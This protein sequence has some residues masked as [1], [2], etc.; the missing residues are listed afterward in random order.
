MVNPQGDPSEGEGA[1]GRETHTGS[2]VEEARRREEGSLV[3]SHRRAARPAVVPTGETELGSLVQVG[4]LVE[5][6]G[7]SMG[8]LVSWGALEAPS[9]GMLSGLCS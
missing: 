4:G 2:G 1:R 8:G 7:G 6:G 9:G 5:R 3:R